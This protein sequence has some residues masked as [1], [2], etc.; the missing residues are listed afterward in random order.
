[1]SERWTGYFLGM[2]AHAAT[3]SKDPSTRV[4]AVL[5]GPDREVRATGFNGLPRGLV[6]SP[7]RLHDRELKLHLV[8]HAELNA[9]LSAARIGTSARGCTMY[10]THPPCAACAAAMVQAGVARVVHR[11]PDPPMVERWRRSLEL[12]QVVLE[13]AGVGVEEA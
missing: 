13:E 11:A 12:G 2:A 5:V 6:D 3:L 9:L 10:I 8:V 7:A 4:G 1:M